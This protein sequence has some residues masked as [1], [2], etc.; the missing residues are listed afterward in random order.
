MDKE[1]I[2]IK[3]DEINQYLREIDEIMPSSSTE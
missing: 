3:I 1:R 2:Y